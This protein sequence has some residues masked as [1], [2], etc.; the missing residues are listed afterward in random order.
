[1][2]KYFCI[3]AALLLAAALTACGGF[4]H[5]EDTNGDDT[6]LCAL[7]EETLT[8]NGTRS[9]ANF[10]STRR[11][12]GEVSFRAEKMSGVRSIYCFRAKDGETYTLEISSA[13]ENGNLRLFVWCDGEILQDVST[14]EA[15]TVFIDGVSGRCEVR[16]AAE[17]A[18]FSVRVVRKRT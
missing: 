10:S 17:S 11:K 3:F 1:M 14:G 15:Q 6:S 5:I 2:K 4:T 12:N 9:L 8:A 13:L 18:K 16:A 7:T